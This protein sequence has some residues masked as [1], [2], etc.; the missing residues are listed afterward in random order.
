[1]LS[2]KRMKGSLLGTCL[3]PWKN[4][5]SRTD[6]KSKATF[7]CG[8]KRPVICQESGSH[9]WGLLDGRLVLPEKT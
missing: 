9:S 7:V 6:I 3:E 2:E 4:L 5:V 1:M 8:L